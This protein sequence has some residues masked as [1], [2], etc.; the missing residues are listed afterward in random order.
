MRRSKERKG[1]EGER[2]RKR[3]RGE[4]KGRVEGGEPRE[5][6]VRE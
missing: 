6:K 5:G 1:E 3:G 2:G 4:G